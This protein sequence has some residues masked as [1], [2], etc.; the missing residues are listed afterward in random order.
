[1]KFTDTAIMNI[2]VPV[3][4]CLQLFLYLYICDLFDVLTS[5]VQ[6]EFDFDS[7]LTYFVNINLF[8]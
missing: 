6:N 3:I 4:S 7:T 5:D 2:V 1:M 8:H